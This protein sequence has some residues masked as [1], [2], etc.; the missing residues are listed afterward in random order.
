M[1]TRPPVGFFEEG[2]SAV[3]GAM[4]MLKENVAD[5]LPADASELENKVAALHS[6]A[7]VHG[8]SMLILDGLVKVDGPV[9]DAL[10]SIPSKTERY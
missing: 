9:L 3:G 10:L 4:H 5:M 6:W 7:L 8:I 2:G 1:S